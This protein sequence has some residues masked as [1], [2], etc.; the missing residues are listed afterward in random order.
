V[1]NHGGDLSHR[2][3]P[4]PDNRENVF[5]P[6]PS[7]PAARLHCAASLPSRFSATYRAPRA[8]GLTS[9]LLLRWLFPY[10]SFVISLQDHHQRCEG[11]L[12]TSIFTAISQHR[13]FNDICDTS[14]SS[15]RLRVS[16]GRSS[17][18]FFFS[19]LLCDDL[20]THHTGS[21]WCHV[22][23]C[24]HRRVAVFTHG[25]CTAHPPS[26]TFT[27]NQLSVFILPKKKKR[28]HGRTV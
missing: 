16:R 24:L 4:S 9:T 15:T 26:E 8:C 7:L 20:T 25:L 21:A 18:T 17:G 5:L 1:W 13:S 28:V 6:F 11:M 3:P 10:Q 27:R 23:R 12:I 19:I 14:S 2:V 22:R